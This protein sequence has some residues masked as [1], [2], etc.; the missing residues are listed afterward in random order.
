[1]VL[2]DRRAVD[3]GVPLAYLITFRSYGTWLHG[4]PRGSVDRFH[5]QYRTPVFPPNAARLGQT[6]IRL[7]RRPV[8]LTVE[9]RRSVERAIQETSEIRKWLLRALNVRTN[10]VHAVVS[11][12]ARPE[13]VLNALKANSTRQ[14]RQDC[15]WEDSCRPWSDGGN[16]RYVWTELGLQRAI[17]YVVNGQDGELPENFR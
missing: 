4:D 5:N 17:D 7:K 8:V 6:E 13:L 12:E 9:Q 2:V 16:K 15:C 10:H 14:L 11:A 3:D 1:M